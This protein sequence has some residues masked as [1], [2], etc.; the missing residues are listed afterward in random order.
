M[1]PAARAVLDRGL[2]VDTRSQHETVMMTADHA[3]RFVVKPVVFLAGLVP[4][5]LLVWRALYGELG[6]NP[7]ETLSRATGDWTMRFL[8]LTLAIRPLR[9]LSGW[10]ALVRLRRMLG[11]YAFFYACLHLLV[12]AGLDLFFDPV[13]I[14]NDV[15]KRPYVTVG[16]ASFLLLVPLA[17]TSTRAAM[18]R[19]G[20]RRW[21]RLHRL[22]YLATAGGVL[23]ELWL[24]KS[25]IREPL[26]YALAA[27]LLL[28]F[29][30]WERWRRRRVPGQP[31]YLVQ[32]PL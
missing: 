31:G 22:V 26:L 29:R 5:A 18:R 8:L 28:G 3:L 4:L 23:H 12:Y 7:I 13:A 6:A 30:L 32:G 1:R 20:G 11:L 24:V 2:R 16:F 21:Q 15:A 27:A 14:L 10:E 17:A 19:L 9:R 25:D